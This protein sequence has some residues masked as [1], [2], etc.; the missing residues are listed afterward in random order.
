MLS[1]SRPILRVRV[2]RCRLNSRSS[3]AHLGKREA[4]ERGEITVGRAPRLSPGVASVKPHRAGGAM[5][6]ERLLLAGSPVDGPVAGL[7]VTGDLTDLVT[8]LILSHDVDEMRVGTCEPAQDL[9]PARIL[10][11]VCTALRVRPSSGPHGLGALPARLRRAGARTG[12][13]SVPASSSIPP[14]AVGV[15]ERPC[16]RPVRRH[17]P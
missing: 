3:R 8:R 4:P 1:S 7:G 17:T 6:G 11:D 9:T 10:A 16:A 5:C 2:S 15:S 13:R 14:R 12:A